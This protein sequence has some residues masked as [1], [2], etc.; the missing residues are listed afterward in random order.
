VLAQQQA[1]LCQVSQQY[2]EEE[3]VEQ[4]L[5]V[6]LLEMAVTVSQVAV[7]V[8]QKTQVL[9]LKLVEMVGMV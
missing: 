4:V 9:Q 7:V 5:L 8:G 6:Q 2:Q 3:R 1:I